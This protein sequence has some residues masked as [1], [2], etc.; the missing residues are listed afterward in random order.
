MPR[1][2]IVG[3]ALVCAIVVST[4]F[5]QIG[6]A[7]V[8]NPPNFS[9][10]LHAAGI[11]ASGA[12]MAAD[13]YGNVFVVDQVNVT[14]TG[15]VTMVGANGG[16]TPHFVSGLGALSQITYNPTDGYCYI[17]S[18]A[19]V[20]P[21]VLSQIWR[22]DPV[23]GAL[24]A[25]SVTLIASG[26][27]IDNAGLM[28]FGT[29]T[30]L[31]G[32]G[33]YRHDPNGPS[34]NATFLSPGFAQNAILQSL[35]S[36]D[37]LI[38]GGNEVRRWTPFAIVP[39]PYYTHPGPFPNAFSTV[40]SL[41]RTPFNQLGAG[42]LIGIREFGTFCFCGQGL[43]ISAGLTGQTP[44]IFASEPYSAPFDGLRCIASG[45]F[46]DEWWYTEQPGPGPLAGHLLWRIRQVPAHDSQG[47]LLTAVSGNAVT[48]HI[49]GPPAGGDPFL[50]GFASAILPVS[51]AQ[52][53][54][55][56]GI[57]DL[58]PL[59]PLYT[60]VFDGIGVFGPPNPFAQIPVGGHFLLT[61]T[62]PPGMTGVA[63]LLQELTVSPNVAPNGLFFISNVDLLVLP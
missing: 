57:V 46:Q 52:F 5:A 8:V 56:Y 36:G 39:V 15:S 11:A 30:A 60:P 50:L 43:T 19:P 35:V 32:A 24:P 25:G 59:H 38:G 2:P 13:R 47:S 41:A 7:P 1:N 34:G 53:L 23:Q 61:V 3:G 18:W 26:F 55:P 33:L 10:S 45:I 27:T 31:Q 48:V 21:V 44:Q 51:L 37:I 63:V 40:N 6:A 42:G 20:L 16:V 17:A 12:S 14:A 54:P 22:I 49:Y 9:V 62:V 28:Y 58:F 29:Q 4:F